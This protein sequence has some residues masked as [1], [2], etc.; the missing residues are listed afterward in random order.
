MRF[1]GEKV[2]SGTPKADASRRT[3]YLNLRFFFARKVVT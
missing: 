1:T 2:R 3:V